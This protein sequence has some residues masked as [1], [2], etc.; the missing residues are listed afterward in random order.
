MNWVTVSYTHL[1]VY[2][3]QACGIYEG[4]CHFGSNLFIIQQ[5]FSFVPALGDIFDVEVA[6]V[7]KP[8]QYLP[9]VEEVFFSHGRVV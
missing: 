9:V 3:R 8:I 1:D 4:L 7:V 2:K 5:P 6:L